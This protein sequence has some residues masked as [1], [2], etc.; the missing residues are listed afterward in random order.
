MIKS[1]SGAGIFGG[2]LTMVKSHF[3]DLRNKNKLN[4]TL[5]VIESNK[6]AEGKS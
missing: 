6:L 1:L 5:K 3:S 2:F 4:R